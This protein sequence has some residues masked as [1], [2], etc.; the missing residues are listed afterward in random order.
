[1]SV[2]TT[3]TA[4]GLQQFVGA[5]LLHR[6]YLTMDNHASL[7]ASRKKRRTALMLRLFTPWPIA[8][9]MGVAGGILLYVLIVIGLRTFSD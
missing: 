3:D 7:Q 4:R 1:M 2:H 5:K 8:L 9:H 6:R